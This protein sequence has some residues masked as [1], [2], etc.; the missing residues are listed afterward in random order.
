M[1]DLSAIDILSTI[2]VG[3]ITIL[4][5]VGK[6]GWDFWQT[7]KNSKG[8]DNVKDISTKDVV[9][10]HQS[11]TVESLNESYLMVIADMNRRIEELQKE[12]M[13]IKTQHNEC[14]EK[15]KVL[16][17]RVTKLTSSARRE[18]V[19]RNN[20]YKSNKTKGK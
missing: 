1:I 7:K 10:A 8:K 11:L 18:R 4:S 13:H 20:K 5:I 17:Q 15:I 9:Q 16:S 3:G 19:K 6:L 12:V 2:I 14:E